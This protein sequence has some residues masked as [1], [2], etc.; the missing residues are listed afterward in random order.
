MSQ[1]SD[2]TSIESLIGALRTDVV[3]PGGAARQRIG[4]RLA[5]GVM[6]ELFASAWLASFLQSGVLRSKAFV[7]LM[8]LPVGIA[9]GALGHAWVV[10]HHVVPEHAAPMAPAV[11]HA[12]LVVEGGAPVAPV[13]PAAP[14]VTP[15]VAPAEPASAPVRVPRPRLAPPLHAGNRELSQL[16]K[17]RTLL[18]DGHAAATLALLNSHF[19]R[20]PRSALEQERQALYVKAL[21]AAD[22]MAE[23]RKRA[24]VFVRRFPR[25][26]LRGSVESAVAPIP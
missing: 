11:N 19:A 4:A 7:V 13:A 10:S 2:E 26:T 21:V 15:V 8:T 16:E 6:A 17:A 18:S 23:A 14:I 9:I 5:V 22:R 12:T 24:A 20:Y 25:S 3:E 1:P